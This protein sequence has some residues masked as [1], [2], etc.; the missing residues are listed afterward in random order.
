MEAVERG[1]NNTSRSVAMR[2][3][4]SLL[5]WGQERRILMLR[6]GTGL[7]SSGWLESVE[8]AVSLTRSPQITSVSALLMNGHSTLPGWV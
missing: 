1:T 5:K 6:S 4:A 8:A 3:L 2:A 7:A